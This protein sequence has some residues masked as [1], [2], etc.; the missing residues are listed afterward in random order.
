MIVVLED[1][2]PVRFDF[3]T[4]DCIFDVS[5]MAVPHVGKRVENILDL[6]SISIVLREDV[7]V[8]SPV[9]LDFGLDRF[10]GFIMVIDC[11]C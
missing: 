10:V 8:S 11:V 1:R 2:F 6:L 9:V 5:K 4:I 3:D 7:N